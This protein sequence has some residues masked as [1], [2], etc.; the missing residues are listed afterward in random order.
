VPAVPARLRKE[1]G[2]GLIELAFAM[3]L[4]NIG[5][6]ALVAAFN[7]GALA[8]RRAA[9]TSNGTAVADKVMEVYRDLRNE[10]IYL[11]SSSIPTSGATYTAYSANSSAYGGTYYTAGSAGPWV[12]E[13][14]TGSGYSPVPATVTTACPGGSCS[15]M[16]NPSPTSATQSVTGP[17]GQSYTVYTYIIMVSV[18]NGGY[19]KQVTIYVYDPQNSTHV[20]AT[21]QSLFDPNV[22]P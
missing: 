3:L 4:L 7:S 17:D 2:F 18:P 16:T 13:N 11:S 9:A 5:I 6:L 21:E 8:V 19:V 10:S 14:T 1:E 20:L 12:T 15:S 22:S